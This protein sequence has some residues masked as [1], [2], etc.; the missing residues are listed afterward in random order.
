M[1][2][3][4]NGF[5]SSCFKNTYNGQRTVLL[6]P[7]THLFVKCQLTKNAIAKL[8]MLETDLCRCISGL[9]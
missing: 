2:K 9:T 4:E 1:K 7:V 6:S 8:Y 3:P 5:L